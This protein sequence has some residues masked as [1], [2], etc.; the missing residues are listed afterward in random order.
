MTTF[1]VALPRAAWL[2]LCNK[3]SPSLGPETMLYDSPEA[4]VKVPRLAYRCIRRCVCVCAC[5][6]SRELD[7]GQACYSISARKLRNTMSGSSDH[8]LPHDMVPQQGLREKV[9]KLGC[10]IL[11]LE[12]VQNFMVAAP[13]CFRI[14]DGGLV[15]VCT[16]NLVQDQAGKEGI[17]LKVPQSLVSCM[18]LC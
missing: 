1:Y 12:L 8:D 16:L 13:S 18:Y 14:R 9:M 2:L 11:R 7:P 17:V 10:A 3:T 6:S 5:A 15:C 4:A